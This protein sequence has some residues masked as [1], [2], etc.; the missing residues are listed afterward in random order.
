MVKTQGTVVKPKKG[1]E[2]GH[3]VCPQQNTVLISWQDG[4]MQMS[5]IGDYRGT[6]IPEIMVSNDQHGRFHVEF[7]HR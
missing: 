5:I 4:D 1:H 7:V 2:I 3:V 6:E